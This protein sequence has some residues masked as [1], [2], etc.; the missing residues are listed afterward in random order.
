MNT[1]DFLKLPTVIGEVNQFAIALDLDGSYGGEWLFGKLCFFIGGCTVG[2]YNLGTSLRD[3]L[4]QMHLILS[5]AGTRM[6]PR[7][8]AMNK[9]LLFDTVWKAIYGDEKTGIEDLAVEECWAKHNITLPVDVFDYVRVF[10]F[11]EE[12]VSRLIWRSMEEDG[13]KLTHET[14]VP[15]GTTERVF[16]ELSDALTQL[17]DRQ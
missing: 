13:D 4:L 9:D 15:I 3:V 12:G 14:R 17:R 1:L 6:N 5:D 7:F 8:T 16:L 2:D 11:D 10:Q